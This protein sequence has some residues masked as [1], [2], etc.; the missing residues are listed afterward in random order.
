M[1]DSHSGG[2]D[3]GEPGGLIPAHDRRSRHGH[4]GVVVWFTGLSGA[5]KSTLAHALGRVLFDRGMQ[6]VVLDGDHLRH[7]LSSDLGFAPADRT[8]NVRR[9]AEV[10]LLFAQVGTIAIVALISPYRADRAQARQIALE[11]GYDFIEVHVD[12]S[13]EVCE[14]R[15][16]KKLY[17]KARAGLI[18]EFTGIDAPYELPEDPE[19]VV[20]TDVTGVGQSTDTLLHFLLRRLIDSGREG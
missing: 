20:R 18:K 1:P 14:R 5:G 3:I 6:V 13:L 15:D 4:R 12:A 7:G 10:A 9:V 19:V 11:G 8:E 17:Q 16:P 2:G